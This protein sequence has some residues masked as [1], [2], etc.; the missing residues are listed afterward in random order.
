M[1][2]INLQ[3]LSNRGKLCLASGCVS[4][5]VGVALFWVIWIVSANTVPLSTLLG[6]PRITAAICFA[7][8][9]LVLVLVGTLAFQ[10]HDEAIPP[11]RPRVKA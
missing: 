10:K 5:L 3:G 11:S 7:A 1:Q 4:L 9:G 6:G 8:N 2:V